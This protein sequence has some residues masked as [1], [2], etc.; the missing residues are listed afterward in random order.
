LWVFQLLWPRLFPRAVH[1]RVHKRTGQLRSQCDLLELAALVLVVDGL[2]FG[3]GSIPGQLC[4]LPGNG[5]QV[6]GR[7]AR[8]EGQSGS[9]VSVVESCASPVVSIEQM[10]RQKQR[11]GSNLERK[12]KYKFRNVFKRSVQK[13][14]SKLK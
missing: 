6:G 4:N 9:P 11:S 5:S 3:L 7:I 8:V 12:S 1:D 2:Q 13:C 14:V 10:Q